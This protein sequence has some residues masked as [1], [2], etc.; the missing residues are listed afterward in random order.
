MR[1]GSVMTVVGGRRRLHS[2]VHQHSTS[3]TDVKSTAQDITR[4][5]ATWHD[6]CGGRIVATQ[7][8]RIRH[9]NDTT[10]ECLYA[11][12]KAVPPLNKALVSA[13]RWCGAGAGS[14]RVRHDYR[15][16]RLGSDG[17]PRT[18][19][20]V[21]YGWDNREA[22]DMIASPFRREWYSS[23]EWGPAT[24]QKLHDARWRSTGSP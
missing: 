9:E 22:D 19:D 12:Q 6:G 2:G 8:A 10:L 16:C 11:H 1:P 14:L 13:P 24:F 15:P 18:A 5:V 20:R 23:K 21:R 4:Q 7:D 3:W 17:L